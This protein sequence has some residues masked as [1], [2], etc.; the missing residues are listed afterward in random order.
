MLKYDNMVFANNLKRLLD[1]KNMTASEFAN[2]I[3]VNKSVV[4]GWLH[5][6]FSPRLNNIDFMCD[7]FDL[8]RSD[9]LDL[10]FELRFDGETQHFFSLL[11]KRPS[12]RKILS[13]CEKVSDADLHKVIAILDLI[14]SDSADV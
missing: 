3:G 7:Y 13:R 10:P 12:L 6:R 5:G 8:T 11:R 4:S 1:E 14:Q 2:I 9:L